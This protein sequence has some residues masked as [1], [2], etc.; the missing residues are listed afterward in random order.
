[1]F[2]LRR[3]AGSVSLFILSAL[4]LGACEQNTTIAPTITPSA[5]AAPTVKTLETSSLPATLTPEAATPDAIPLDAIPPIII[6]PATVTTTLAANTPAITST[7]RNPVGTVGQAVRL[8]LG[9][10]SDSAPTGRITSIMTLTWVTEGKGNGNGNGKDKR[11]SIGIMVVR[12]AENYQQQRKAL[13]IVGNQL[14][15]KLGEERDNEAGLAS[16]TVYIVGA[17]AYSVRQSS[18]DDQRAT[19]TLLTREQASHVFDTLRPDLLLGQLGDP[20]G[21]RGVIAATNQTGSSVIETIKLDGATAARGKKDIELLQGDA[22]VV[23]RRFMAGEPAVTPPPNG[24]DLVYLQRFDAVFEGTPRFLNITGRLNA[25][26]ILTLPDSDVD[27][28]LPDACKN[29]IGS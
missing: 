1:M 25:S 13:T 15:V 4:L 9:P 6:E 22:V 20:N 10:F 2:G 27:I 24:R 8:Y 21:L 18:S 29:A 16:T 7:V 17:N 12:Y 23:H 28:Q 26:Y 3:L 5:Y 14:A 19:C 11:N